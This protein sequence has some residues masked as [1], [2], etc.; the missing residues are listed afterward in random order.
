MFPSVGNSGQTAEKQRTRHKWRKCRTYWSSSPRRFPNAP[1]KPPSF[2]TILVPSSIAFIVL[3]T[4]PVEA[5]GVVGPVEGTTF[6]VVTAGFTGIDLEANGAPGT[7]ASVL[8]TGVVW[9]VIETDA[10][11]LAA[12]IAV[13]NLGAPPAGVGPE[14]EAWEAGLLIEADDAPGLLVDVAA[15][16]LVCF[17]TAVVV[18]EAGLEVVVFVAELAICGVA[19]TSPGFGAAEVFTAW[20]GAGV[21]GLISAILIC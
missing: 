3:S 7:F 6:A 21:V 18:L 16:G 4:L 11:C 9:G 8:A 10:V 1:I 14:N 17:G 12:G 5:A 2:A 13:A 15:V 19:V 20:A